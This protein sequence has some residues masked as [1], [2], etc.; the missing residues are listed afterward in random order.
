MAQIFTGEEKQ[1]KTSTESY[2]DLKAPELKD[3]I[4]ES[5]LAQLEEELELVDGVYPHFDLEAYRAG[6]LQPV[7]FG[8][9]L[10]NFGVQ[11][12][13]D[14]FVDIA[15]PPQPKA[16]DTVVVAPDAA[17]FSGFVFKIHANMDPNHRDRLAFV[18]IVSGVFKRNTPLFACAPQ[19]KA[20][21]FE[22]QCLFCREKAG[23]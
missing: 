18:K 22:P 14:C 5:I 6:A 9:A 17:D 12:L 21:V 4:G 3:R 23:C 2:A 16:A 1:S 13:L 20:K 11:D 19:Q 7:F 10:N 8:S 15:P